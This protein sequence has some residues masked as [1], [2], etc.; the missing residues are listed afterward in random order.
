MKSGVVDE[1]HVGRV[2]VMDSLLKA[3]PHPPVL[4][5]RL[6]VLDNVM[7]GGVHFARHGYLATSVG[8]VLCCRSHF[9]LALGTALHVMG[10]HK[11][12]GGS[13][14][15]GRRNLSMQVS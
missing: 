14:H 8:K 3:V 9:P 7:R 2:D 5:C 1:R 15:F 6:Y 4:Q 13:L 12:K 10:G 11:F